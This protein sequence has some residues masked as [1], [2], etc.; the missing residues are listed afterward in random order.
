MRLLLTACLVTTFP[1]GAIAATT[2]TVQKLLPSANS[3]KGFTILA[4]SLV[5]GKGNDISKIYNGGY[6]L[7]TDNGVIDAARQMYQRG[8]DYVEVTVHTMK[9][10]KAALDF[11]KYWQKENKAKSL[12]KSGGSTGF[13]VTK[14]GV[15]AYFVRGKY[16]ATVSAFHAEEK[17]ANDAATFRSVIDKAISKGQ[18][19]KR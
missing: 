6:E 14:P 15:T 2:P 3:V 7:Y 13:L 18:S 9:S 16:F 19:R 5:Y 4:D 10:D 8:G 1:A 11:L 17:A 12:A